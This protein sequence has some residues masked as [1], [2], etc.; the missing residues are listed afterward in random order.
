MGHSLID[1]LDTVTHRE[2]VRY[3]LRRLVE[4]DLEL[5][6]QAGKRGPYLPGV[7][8]LRLGQSNLVVVRTL[9]LEEVLVEAGV[10]H[11][12]GGQFLFSFDLD[13]DVEADGS[14]DS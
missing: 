9:E 3:V 12:V 1:H 2:L 6:F 11:V 4:K 14:T 10:L 7:F 8:S 13:I 5:I